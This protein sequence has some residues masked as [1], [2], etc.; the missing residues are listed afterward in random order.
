VLT[1]ADQDLTAKGAMVQFIM[2][3]GRV[4]FEIRSDAVQAGGLTL[5]SKLLA[6]SASQKGD[7]R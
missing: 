1:V 6:L 7:N 5:S 2:V 3:D 4:R